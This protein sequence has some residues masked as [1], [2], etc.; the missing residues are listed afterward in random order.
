[1]LAL[2]FKNQWFTAAKS[3]RE[4]LEELASGLNCRATARQWCFL[5]T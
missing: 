4:P 1:M 3:G 5:V 2:G